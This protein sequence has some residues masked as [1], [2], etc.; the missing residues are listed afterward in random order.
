MKKIL[1]LF[2]ILGS[3][4]GFAQK[5]EKIHRIVQTMP[6][7]YNGANA[8]QNYIRTN[9]VYPAS[10][11]EDSIEGVVYVKFVINEN[12]D[13]SNVEIERGIREDLNEVAIQVISN[14]PAWKPGE[15]D[16][17]KVKVQYI[18]PIQFTLF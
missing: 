13:I 8:L 15:Q 1:F 18:V 11:I 2:C 10:A 9:L 14:M 7:F 5:N 6:E 3:Y 17:E 12:G 4:L 16:G